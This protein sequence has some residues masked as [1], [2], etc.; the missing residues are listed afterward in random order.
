MTEQTD[1][2]IKKTL[3]EITVSSHTGPFEVLS[4]LKHLF[5]QVSLTG[6]LALPLTAALC[7]LS[8]KEHH[9]S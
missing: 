3:Q 9:S 1:S 7:F 8:I 5:L 2:H 6:K 4:T